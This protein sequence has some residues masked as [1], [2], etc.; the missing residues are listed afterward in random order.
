MLNVH[1][2]HFR[3]SYFPHFSMLWTPVFYKAFQ[4][5]F[6]GFQKS[7]RRLPCKKSIGM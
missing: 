4:H 1:F 3:I 5:F 2:P 6:H 7:V